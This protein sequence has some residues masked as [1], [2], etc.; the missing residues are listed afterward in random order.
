MRSCVGLFGLLLLMGWAGPAVAHGI[1]LESTPKSGETV[2]VG[3]SQVALRFNSRI[4]PTL[5]RLRL[6]GPPGDV[7]RLR[8]EPSAA[9]PN[10]L[11]AAL[12]DLQTGLYTVHWRVFTVDGHVTHGSFSFHVARGIEEISRSSK[13]EPAT[14][15]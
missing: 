11:A 12:P 1:L 15:W 14:E 6:T 2:A 3:V 4:E 7:A 10:W 13:P 8:A 5:S 9:G